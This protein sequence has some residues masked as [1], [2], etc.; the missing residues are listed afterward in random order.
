MSVV[1]ADISALRAAAVQLRS[2]ADDLDAASDQLTRQLGSMR[3][4]GNVAVQFTDS[5]SSL[6]RGRTRTLAQFLR[7]NADLLERNAD[8][9]HSASSG[10]GTGARPGS[11]RVE[12]FEPL[13]GRNA[14]VEA[15]YATADGRRAEGH[16][17]EIRQLENGRWI[18]VLPGVVDLSS[19]VGEVAGAA[20][21]GDV[22]APWFDGEQP[23]TA[24]RMEYASLEALD[25]ADQF[26][27]PYARRVIEQMK[28]AG[29]PAGA[30]VMIMG[31]SF[32][33]YTAMELAGNPMFN[34]SDGES[35]GY[36]VNVTH[37]LAAG[38]DTDWKLSEVPG[39]TAALVLNNRLDL[40]VR[41]ED[42]LQGNASPTH[43]NHAEVWFNGDFKGKGHHPDNYATYLSD[44]RNPQ[45]SSFLE[46]AAQR[47][48]GQ[49]ES[50]TREVRD[51]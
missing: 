29:I 51:D 14:L 44:T 7:D 20:L 11:R 37:V 8:Q 19:G 15:F 46:T 31:H 32:G 43:A 28:L 16:E 12:R 36:H 38:A 4:L 26:N 9:Q 34:S 48:A 6:H 23:D 3:W 50:F 39:S 41:G 5:W 2:E 1:G 35:A 24:R 18:I 27:N 13:V 17:I 10:D 45:V 42:A 40:V 22:L 33:A 49:G 21:R 30:E 47:Y 25:D